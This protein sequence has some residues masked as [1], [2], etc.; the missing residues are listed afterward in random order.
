MKFLSIDQ[1]ISVISDL[2]KI[3][4]DLGH[5]VK[6]VSLSGHAQIIGKPLAN[7][8]ELSGDNWCGTISEKKFKE[9]YDKYK[10]FLDQFDGFICCYPPA[11]AWLYKYTNKPI[12]IQIPIRYEYG[13]NN[14]P[15]QW[16]EFNQYLQDGVDNKKIFLSANSE[17]DK[18]YAESFLDRE[19]QYIPSLC[20]YTGM[21]YNPVNPQFLSYSSKAVQ[22]DKNRLVWKIHALPPRHN[23][24]EVAN[25]RGIVH[26]PYQVSTMS[27][28][29]QYTANIPLFF[30]SKRYLLE[31]WGAGIEV[32]QQSSWNQ[33]F[34]KPAGSLINPNCEYDPN[35]YKN[36]S[37]VEHW[38]Q[39]ADYYTE[40]MKHVQ[41]FDS[42]AQLDSMLSTSDAELRDISDR[43]RNHNLMRKAS[44]HTRWS[45]ILNEVQHAK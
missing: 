7:I 20:E 13:C 37:A 35:D 5:S 12:I 44:V 11:F 21:T 25:Y 1:H 42:T 34:N 32:L 14:T 40:G 8:P 31:L 23:W 39:Y 4:N 17:Y 2:R 45:K 43:M 33:V 10:G 6:E 28:F 27:I 29:E 26:F 9:F 3:F 41:L 36:K 24:Q 22:D 30:P 38:L 16:I 19:V 18:H 15:E